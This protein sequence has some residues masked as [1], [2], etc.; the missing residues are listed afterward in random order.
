MNRHLSFC[1]VSYNGSVQNSIPTIVLIVVF[2]EAASWYE[3]TP[4]ELPFRL[5]RVAGIFVFKTRDTVWRA[6]MSLVI[7]SENPTE[8]SI[9]SIGSW[10]TSNQF[11][12]TQ[13]ISLISSMML[14]SNNLG[15]PSGSF[16]KRF[17]CQNSRLPCWN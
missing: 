17:P 7:E 3:Q 5:L 10:A 2:I 8:F 13:H 15:H 12:T 9:L 1:P 4:T 6:T 16:P 11:T 14:S